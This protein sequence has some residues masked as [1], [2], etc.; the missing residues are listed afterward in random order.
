MGYEILGSRILA[1]YFGGSV[2]TWGA[3]IS[4]FMLGLSI[5]YLI[6]GKI[7]DKRKSFL[8]LFYLF[9]VATLTLFF[10]S[11]YGKYICLILLELSWDIRYTA[12]TAS[13]LLFLLPGILWGAVLPYLI[14]MTECSQK[15]IGVS[16]GRIYSVSTIGSILGVLLVSFYMVGFVGTSNGIRLLCV[17]LFICSL[18]SLKLVFKC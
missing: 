18:I 8:D 5:G 15:N 9:I 6:G 10:V 7:A 13:L 14:K 17:P 3:L 2:Y 11:V 4:V 16:V 12:L 1:P